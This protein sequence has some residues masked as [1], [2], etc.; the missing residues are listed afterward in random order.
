MRV[1]FSARTHVGMRREVNQD[2]YG[3]GEPGEATLLVVC[4]GMGGHAA[5]EVASTLGVET[6][7]AAYR[8]ELAPGE[9]LREAFTAAN[10]RI[11]EE[12]RGSMGT[13]GVAALFLHN[14]LHVA[15]VGDSRA[16]LVRE[17]EIV[18]ISQD[19]S[20][21]S[22]QVAAG[23]MTPEQARSSNIRNI[24]TRALGHSADVQVDLFSA[25]LRPGDTV[26]LSSDGMHGLITDEEIA[27]VTGVLTLEEAAQR[28]VDT[29]NERGGTDNI[30]V[31]I[32]RVDELDAGA[33]GDPRSAETRPLAAAA[34]R[35]LAAPTERLP[36][37]PAPPEKPLSRIGAA[38][39]AITLVALLGL[40]GYALFIPRP[41]PLAAP[42]PSAATALPA[43]TPASAPS[44]PPAT[45]APTGPVASPPP[46]TRTPTA[47]PTTAP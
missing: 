28:L 22:D 39:A 26:V 29:A 44:P 46:A 37:P 32:A 24:I 8:A 25:P 34:T 16:Y 15:N 19:H 4:D 9:A 42:R 20:F 13:T 11:Y 30:T 23:L 43:A 47:A 3:S 6:I 10:K 38:L 35:P 1:R 18:Q 7:V 45:A 40:G 27:E 33:P 17:D 2:A 12:G 21:V 36:R 5:G 31:V 41:T 14:V